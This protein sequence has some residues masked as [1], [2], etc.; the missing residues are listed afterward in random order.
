MHRPLKPDGLAVALILAILGTSGFNVL[1]IMPAVV[2][3]LV[4]GLHIPAGLAGR[5]GSCDSY[6]MAAGAVIAVFIV[7]RLA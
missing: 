1:L 5:I 2:S 3:G 6:G 4:D 7:R